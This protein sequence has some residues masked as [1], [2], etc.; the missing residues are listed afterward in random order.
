MEEMRQKM[1]AAG[2][3]G[4]AHEAL[5]V[6]VG[7]WTAEVKSWM[8]P[9]APPMVNRGTA[10]VTWVMNGRFI[11]EEFTGEFSGRIFHGMSLMGYDNSKEKY[12]SVWVDDVSTAIITSEGEASEE[13]KVF[14]LEGKY[15]CP[16]TGQKD[17][18]MKQVFRILGKDKHIFEMH[19]MSKGENSKTMEITYTRK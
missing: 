13:A 19:D 3:P 2:K 9:D 4:G 17:T 11:Q 15:H 7:D 18:P 10:K 16:M 14:T 5:D 12:T 1:E 6:L 8:A